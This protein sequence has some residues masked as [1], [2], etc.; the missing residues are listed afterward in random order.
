MQ[1]AYC[2]NE[3]ISSHEKKTTFVIQKER[4]TLNCKVEGNLKTIK[5]RRID[6]TVNHQVFLKSYSRNIYQLPFKCPAEIVHHNV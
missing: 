3:N 1:V 5:H 6:E 2:K 4:N